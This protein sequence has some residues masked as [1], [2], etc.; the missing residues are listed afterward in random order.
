M[1][2]APPGAVGRAG[3]WLG[4]GRWKRLSVWRPGPRGVVT[5]RRY[6]RNHHPLIAISSRQACARSRS[7]NP[8]PLWSGHLRP[9]TTSG[10]GASLA[11]GRPALLPAI[12]PTSRPRALL[13]AD[14]DRPARRG[15][16]N[17]DGVEK[18]LD[19][20]VADVTAA[21]RGLVWA[22]CYTREAD[23]AR[24]HTS[25]MRPGRPP[26]SGVTRPCPPRSLEPI[27]RETG[28]GSPR[29]WQNYPRSLMSEIHQ[30]ANILSP[31]PL[32]ARSI[33]PDRRRQRHDWL[34]RQGPTTSR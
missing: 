11:A 25:K 31:F 21:R 23:P 20:V 33:D 15:C 6:D 22:L 9:I 4:A 18:R 7:K 26:P 32:A 10:Q 27:N 16:E 8:T 24:A 12:P 34:L 29:V 3:V 19:T 1:T 5:R 30:S 14:Q 28:E 17:R 13:V 2:G